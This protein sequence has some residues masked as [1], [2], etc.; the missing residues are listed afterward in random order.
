MDDAVTKTPD[1]LRNRLRT[2]TSG[3]HEALDTLASTFDLT[4]RSGLTAFLQM[5]EA[6]LRALIGLQTNCICAGAMQDLHQRALTD[7]ETLGAEPLPVA[8]TI[9]EPF[10]AL[11]IDYV[12]A[13]SR[14]GAQVLERRWRAATDPDI[15]RASAFFTA[16]TYIECWRAVCAQCAAIDGNGSTARTIVLHA[17]RIFALYTSCANAARTDPGPRHA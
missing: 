16:P 2:E 12:I 4:E 14:L 13:G 3:A 17:N 10:T 1:N 8:L 15:T 9:P 5:H 6:A 11:A 7:L